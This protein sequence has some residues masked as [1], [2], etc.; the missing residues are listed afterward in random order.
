MWPRR[1]PPNWGYQMQA[2]WAFLGLLALLILVNV[3]IGFGPPRVVI[4][5]SQFLNLVGRGRVNDVA[6]SST[7]VSGVY[8]SPQGQ[9]LFVAM[10]PPQVDS[11]A[12]LPALQSKGITFT[13]SQPSALGRFV[14]GLLLSWLL[15]FLLLAGL[16]GLAMRR[17]GP[18]AGA[19]Q[20]GRSRH[21]IYNR[22]DLRTTFADVAGLDEAVE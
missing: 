11:T 12:L 15:P 21:K 22:K 9:Q 14:T 18:G 19:M 20:F 1:F 13:G 10:R 8:G 5:Y 16:W 2:T 17:L 6:I 7:Q 3:L 4:P